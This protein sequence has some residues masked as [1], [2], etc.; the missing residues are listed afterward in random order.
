MKLSKVK[1]RV[2]H[3]GHGNSWNQHIPGEEQA[4]S[5]PAEKDL[6]VLAE[7]LDTTQARALEP[8]MSWAACRA[9][10]AAGEGGGF[11]LHSTLLKPHTEYYITSGALGTGMTPD[12]WSR[13]RGSHQDG[14]RDEHLALGGKAQGTRV[15]Q[16]GEE[17][18]PGRPQC[19]LSVPRVIL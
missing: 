14:Q 17:E 18:G 11:P 15:A 9:V 10:W 13:S 2:P 5:S 1:C 19:S 6:W 4:K 7:E 12:H 8:N 3:L 16:P